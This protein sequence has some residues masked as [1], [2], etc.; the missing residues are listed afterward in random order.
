MKGFTWKDATDCCPTTPE[1]DF[2]AL[3][4][5]SD[6]RVK[7]RLVMRKGKIL[8]IKWYQKKLRRLEKGRK[9]LTI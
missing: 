8:D 7:G 2:T 4:G 3:Y 5:T 9:G 1:D 6:V